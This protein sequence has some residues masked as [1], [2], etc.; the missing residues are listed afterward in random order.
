MSLS[1][2][3][4]RIEVDGQS[5]SSAEGAVVR[6]RVAAGLGGGH[7]RAEIVCWPPSRFEGSAPGAAATVALG[8]SGEEEP[9]WAGEVI[10]CRDGPAGIEIEG[11]APTVRLS[12]ARISRTYLDQS[13]AEIIKDL[14]AD[15]PMGEVQAD[16]RVD[17]YHVDDRQTVW[18]HVLALAELAGVEVA[19]SPGGELR[20][21]PPRSGRAD[22]TLRHGADLLWWDF[23]PAAE[24]VSAIAAAHG[25]GSEGGSWH[26]IRRDVGAGDE[27]SLRVVG[28]FG[29][30]DAADGLTES[31]A[32]RSRD[33][34]RHGVVVA[35]G[36]PGI[37]PGDL[38]EL[39]DL[40]GEDPG[41][42]RVRT[43]DHRLDRNGFITVLRLSGGA[44]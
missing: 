35:V 5:L 17:A 6:V 39:E 26:W 32:R 3:V 20:V 7:D 34:G 16:V 19:A 44:A 25:A 43:V 8:E 1:R 28:A 15:V 38:V 30:R 40:P 11:L 33:A 18:S 13:A 36:R 4:A 29:N 2:P 12:R 31:L 9:A 24:Q 41:V 14:A 23:G 37:R 22:V 42:L 21:T 27:S 10:A